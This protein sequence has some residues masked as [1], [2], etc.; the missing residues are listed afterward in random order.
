MKTCVAIVI[1]LSEMPRRAVSDSENE[2]CLLSMGQGRG[3]SLP[4]RSPGSRA[5]KHMAVESEGLAQF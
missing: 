3:A 1:Q 5:E 2:A 4:P